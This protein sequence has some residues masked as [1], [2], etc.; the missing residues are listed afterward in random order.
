VLYATGDSLDP[1]ESSMQTASRSLQPFT[2][3]SLGDRPTDRPRYSVGNNR[4]STQWRSQTLLLSTATRCFPGPTRVLDANGISIAAA[5]FA[6]LTKWQTDW[7]TN[8]PLFV[9]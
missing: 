2:Q 8:R 7:Q 6:G 9:L 5:V 3:G 1:P 4:R